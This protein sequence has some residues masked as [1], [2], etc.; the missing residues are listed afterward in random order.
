MEA[1]L[2]TLLPRVLTDKATFQVYPPP[3]QER[4]TAQAVPT[5]AR[6]RQ[7]AAC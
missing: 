7:L 3:G 6:V 2:R 1:F 5:T 4:L